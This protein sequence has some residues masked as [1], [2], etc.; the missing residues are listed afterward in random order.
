MGKRWDSPEWREF[1]RSLPCRCKDPRCPNCSG[2]VPVRVICA[3]MRSQTGLGRKPHDLWTYPLS[4]KVHQVFHMRGQPSLAWQIQ[5]IE[6]VWSVAL[7]RGIIRFDFD[8][9]EVDC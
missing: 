8:V 3:H 9:P 4:D 7:T 1:V 6:E 5:R 2:G